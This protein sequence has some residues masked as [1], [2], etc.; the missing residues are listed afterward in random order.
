MFLELAKKSY[1]FF[2][3]CKLKNFF[4]IKFVI[5]IKFWNFVYFV[6]KFLIYFKECFGM[7]ND[8]FIGF[9]FFQSF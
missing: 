9:N 5:V 2:H 4:L 7:F 6:D 3:C 1:T 8:I